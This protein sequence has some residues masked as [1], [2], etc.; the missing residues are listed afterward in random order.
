[1]GSARWRKI[2]EG[3]NMTDYIEELKLKGYE[4]VTR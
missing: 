1:M 4:E 2:K 3:Y